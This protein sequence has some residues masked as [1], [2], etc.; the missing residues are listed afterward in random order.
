M[1]R[2]EVRYAKKNYISE[3]SIHNYFI[4]KAVNIVGG[5]MDR[6][7]VNLMKQYSVVPSTCNF[8]TPLVVLFHVLSLN[9]S[10]IIYYLSTYMYEARKGH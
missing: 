9:G 3:F 1:H 4:K 10:C 7:M 8:L 6:F 2:V 5:L